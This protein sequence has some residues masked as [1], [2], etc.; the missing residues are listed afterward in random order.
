MCEELNV[1]GFNVMT[2]PPADL[3]QGAVSVRFAQLSVGETFAVI[4]RYIH[5]DFSYS[6]RPQYLDIIHGGL[7][8]SELSLTLFDSGN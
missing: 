5:S 3:V 8:F 2:P 1:L 6:S 7:K 4:V